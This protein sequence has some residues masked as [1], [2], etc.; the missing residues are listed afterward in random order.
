[1]DAIRKDSNLAFILKFNQVIGVGIVSSR[2]SLYTLW[3]LVSVFFTTVYISAFLM[4]ML[5]PAFEVNDLYINFCELA[6]FAKFLSLLKY[7]VRL[8]QLL[9]RMHFDGVFQVDENNALEVVIVKKQMKKYAKYANT[10]LGMSMLAVS[11][12]MTTGFGDPPR[13]AFPAW[14]PFGMND[15]TVPWKFYVVLLYQG[16]PMFG[17]AFVNI[18]WDNLL[19]YVLTNVQLQFELLNHRLKEKLVNVAGTE[20]EKNLKGIF[21]TFNAI[22]R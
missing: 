4:H 16:I 2:H 22:I 11:F 10:Y 8:T 1:M 3:T 14:Y 17:H 6:M 5:S 21:K 13:K 18:C 19:M 9:N 12:A 7:R 15:M 20:N